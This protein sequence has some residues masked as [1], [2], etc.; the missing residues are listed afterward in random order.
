MASTFY[1]HFCLAFVSTA[2]TEDLETINYSVTQS[3]GH[4]AS[5]DTSDNKMPFKKDYTFDVD[6]FFQCKVISVAH[7]QGLQLIVTNTDTGDEIINEK[8]RHLT[9]VNRM[10]LTKGS[11]QI[12][13]ISHTDQVSL[14]YYFSLQP[15]KSLNASQYKK[16]DS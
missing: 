14:D 13:L 16:F 9:Y 15:Y 1:Q 6:Q 2:S 7:N 8:N 10:K 12:Q 3:T 11:Y 4:F 5:D